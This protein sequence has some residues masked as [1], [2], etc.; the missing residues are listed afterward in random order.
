MNYTHAS[1]V[2]SHAYFDYDSHY[3]N[4]TSNIIYYSIV[5]SFSGK[6]KSKW[7]WVPKTNPSG[8]KS[9]WVPIT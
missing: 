5:R 6:P 7:I 2:V 9:P 1:K 4:S 3:K 8:P